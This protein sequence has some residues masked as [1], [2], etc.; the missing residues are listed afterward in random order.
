MDVIQTLAHHHGS[1]LVSIGR[2]NGLYGTRG[3]LKIYSYTRPRDNILAYPTWKLSDNNTWVPFKFIAHRRQGA[4]FVASLDG[5][6]DRDSATQWIGSEIAIDRAALPEN[7]AGEYYW[8]DLI[9]LDVFNQEGVLLGTITG[10]LETGANDVLVV[11]G[12]REHLIPYV[13]VHYVAQVDLERGCM[14]VHW[15]PDD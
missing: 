8:T 3:W 4:G 5:I 11:N 1:G 14:V 2:V 13:M 7:A 6:L 10:L 9:G 12:T 15:H